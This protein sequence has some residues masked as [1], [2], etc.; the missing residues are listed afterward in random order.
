[1]C[2]DPDVL[3]QGG[4]DDGDETSIPTLADAA[5]DWSPS[6]AEAAAAPAEAAADPAA[7]RPRSDD[8]DETAPTPKRVRCEV[9]PALQRVMM[10]AQSVTR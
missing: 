7:R 2:A 4:S 9:R 5:M 10:C 6:P 3:K 8:E 1:M